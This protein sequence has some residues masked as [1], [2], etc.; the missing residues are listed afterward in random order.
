MGTDTEIQLISIAYETKIV[1]GQFQ[2]SF[3]LHGVT[4]TTRCW[5]WNSTEAT[6]KVELERL[7]IIDHVLVEFLWF[8]LEGLLH[9]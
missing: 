1:Q 9:W 2:L 6:L 7:L 3:S 4:Q 5:K 8:Q